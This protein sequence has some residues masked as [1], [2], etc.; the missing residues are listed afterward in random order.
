MRLQRH[1]RAFWWF[2]EGRLAGMARPGFNRSHWSDL[3]LEEAMVLSW[4]GK[5]TDPAP[6]LDDLWQYFEHYGPKVALFY[7]LTNAEF[8]ERLSHLHERQAL[9]AVL[10]SLSAKTHMFHDVSWIDEDSQARLGVTYNM[11][12]LYDEVALLKQHGISVLISLLEHPLDHHILNEHF[13]V[14]HLPIEDATPPSR[15]QVFRLAE[16]LHSNLATGRNVAVHCLAGVGRTTTMLIAAHLVQGYA[17]HDMTAWI[18]RCNPYF[19][20]RGS[21]ARFVYELAEDIASGREA[22]LPAPSR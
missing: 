14:Q 22:V 12:R 1:M 5:Q 6:A 3:S 18:R 11:Q 19:L 8:S 13:T 10:E 4:L 15:E 21:Q 2:M 7:D 16:M 9:L 20:F 17:L